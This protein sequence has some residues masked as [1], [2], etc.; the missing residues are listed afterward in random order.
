MGVLADGL[1]WLNS[2]RKAHMSVDVAYK[3][4]GY[5][6]GTIPATIG[7]T[8]IE[9]SD[10]SGMRIDGARLDFLIEVSDLVLGGH[11]IEPEP[12]DEIVATVSGEERTFEVNNLASEGAWRW[13]D[14]VNGVYRIHTKE[15]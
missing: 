13:S 1:K 2:E 15:I 12:G 14:T 4:T 8:D 5:P 10:E 3:R 7:Q 6:T 11:T 9:V